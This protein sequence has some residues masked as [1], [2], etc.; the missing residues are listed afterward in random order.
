MASRSLLIKFGTILLA[1]LLVGVVFFINYS[2]PSIGTEIDRYKGVA[3]YY[4]GTS[5]DQCHGRH[6]SEDGYYYGEKWQCV[7][8]V[9]RFYYVLMDHRMPDTMGHAKDF[10]DSTVPQGKLN[11]RRG[12]VQYRNG[13]N[14][15][16]RGDDLLV[17]ING[18]YGHVAIITKVG[19]DMIEVVQQNV[20][21]QTRQQFALTI[22]NGHYYVGEAEQPAGWLRKED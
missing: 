19:K 21:G 5:Y 3:I 1:L 13:G 9:K 11:H 4:N 14:V 10:F 18:K 16:P 17:F 7:E 8:F 15:K 6:F 2:S 20:I 12:L 22:S